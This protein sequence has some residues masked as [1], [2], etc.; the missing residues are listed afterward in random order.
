MSKKCLSIAL[1]MVL[2]LGSFNSTAYA[3]GMYPSYDFQKFASNEVYKMQEE[4][5][6]VE[7]EINRLSAKKYQDEL[8]VKELV[9]K[10]SKAMT[11][12]ER[13]KNKENLS[14]LE[15]ELQEKITKIESVRAEL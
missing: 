1:A 2:M 3:N 14:K 9:E 12:S 5:I 11:E 10:L 4:I 13:L 6:R 15:Q 7:D 8:L